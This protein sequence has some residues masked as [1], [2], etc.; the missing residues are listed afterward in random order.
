MRTKFQICVAATKVQELTV[1]WIPFTSPFARVCWLWSS[2]LLALQK[3][4]LLVSSFFQVLWWMLQEMSFT[5]SLGPVCKQRVY[6]RELETVLCQIPA[7]LINSQGAHVN[8]WLQT[9]EAEQANTGLVHGALISPK[10]NLY[11]PMK[12]LPFIK[13][14]DIAGSLW[15]IAT[16]VIDRI[17]KLSQNSKWSQFKTLCHEMSWIF[18]THLGWVRVLRHISRMDLTSSP[19]PNTPLTLRGTKLSFSCSD[20]YHLQS[21][22]IHKWHGIV[23]AGQNSGNLHFN[24]WDSQPF[25]EGH[26]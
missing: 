20:T 13:C 21:V 11:H 16:T 22:Q 1:T 9:R 24:T 2:Q 18:K 19:A 26:H 25:R 14:V 15:L 23:N 3:Q 5:A 8:L 17:N 6:L 7:N 10:T 12:Y 4:I